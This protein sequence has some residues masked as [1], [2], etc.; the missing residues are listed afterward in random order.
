MNLFL[1]MNF[2]LLMII[3]SEYAMKKLDA[4]QSL[5]ELASSIFVTVHLLLFLKMFLSDCQ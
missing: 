1:G 3:F 5:A 4:P 2:Y